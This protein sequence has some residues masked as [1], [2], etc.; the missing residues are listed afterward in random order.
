VGPKPEQAGTR[1][2]KVRRDG[3]ARNL[4]QQQRE[5]HKTVMVII[6]Q[7]EE[8]EYKEQ[9]VKDG[10]WSSGLEG[11]AGHGTGKVGEK[12]RFCDACGTGW[13]EVAEKGPHGEGGGA[14]GEKLKDKRQKETK[15]KQEGFQG[16]GKGEPVEMNR[17]RPLSEGAGTAGKAQRGEGVDGTVAGG[18]AVKKGRAKYQH[19]HI[20][21]QCKECGGASICEH[22]R[23]R[24]RCKQC[25]GASICEHHRRRSD[26]KECGGSGIC[27]HNRQR[28]RCKQCGGS[29]ICEHNRR[30]SEC[31]QYGGSSICEH[32]RERSKCKD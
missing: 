24:S 19:N 5:E 25:G 17:R 15:H 29:G 7:I 10:A 2:K 27:E 28:S 23:I 14:G 9:A 32:N 30:R 12:P 18:G 8:M 16:K 13:G 26:C 11:R 20:R 21:S 4:S 1:N 6:R 22:N 31:K 3:E